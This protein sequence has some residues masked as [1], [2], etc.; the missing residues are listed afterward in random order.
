MSFPRRTVRLR[1]T[2]LYGGLFLVTGALLV[3]LVYLLAAHAPLPGAPPAPEVPDLG[4]GLP[5]PP[6]PQPPAVP[7]VPGQA[8]DVQRLLVSSVLGLAVMSAASLALGW[9]VAGRVLHPLA[10]MTATVRQISADDL[11]RRLVAS[12]PD[13]ELTEL[14]DTFDDLL[15]RLERAFAAQRRF[16]ANA[17]HE[18]RTPLTL[19][20]ATVEVALADPDATAD[21]LR[22]TLQRVLASGEHQERIIEALLVLARSQQGLAQR[23]EVDVAALAAAALDE[24]HSDP[25]G[26]CP[27]ASRRR[28]V[29]GHTWRPDLSDESAVRPIRV[30]ADLPSAR[31]VGD[32]ELLARLVANLLSNAVLH[33]VPDGWVRVSTSS[34]RGGLVLAV[35]NSGPV[36][37]PDRVADLLEP[38]R[39][40]G[41][42]RIGS[43]GL[44]LGL[45]I[46]AAITDA[47]GGTLALHPR[48]EGGLDVRVTLPGQRAPSAT[49]W[50]R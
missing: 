27:P 44:G 32:R 29:T 36:V 30:D 18:L 13:D 37:P 6:A 4:G 42:A 20:R 35:A 33:N 47:H 2:L 1:L 46:V 25:T 24:R 21:S 15:D 19:Q 40:L 22:G 26:D 28:S 3:G 11:H 10:T 14:S 8:I 49:S 43:R 41:T 23:E 7:E 12:G 16:V 38:F 45:S 9:L 48:P 17:S 34:D 31:V 39:R 5:E 50:A